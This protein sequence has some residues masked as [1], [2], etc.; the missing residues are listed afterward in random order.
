MTARNTTLSSNE[1][2]KLE[3]GCAYAIEM[4]E[5]VTRETAERIKRHAEE[6]APGCRFLVLGSGVRLARHTPRQVRNQGE[7]GSKPVHPHVR[8]EQSKYNSLIYKR[9]IRAVFSTNTIDQRI[10]NDKISGRYSF[11]W[12]E[13]EKSGR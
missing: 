6:S 7:G 3:P 10:T 4:N 12:F 2:I 8:G 13:A 5:A 1:A 9:K 11:Q